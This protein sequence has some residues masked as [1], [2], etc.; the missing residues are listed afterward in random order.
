MTDVLLIQPPIS[1]FYLTAKRTFPYGLACIATALEAD[2]FSVSLFDALATGRSRRLPLP[3]EM[4]YLTPFY[5]QPDLS[6]FALFHHHR[7]FGYSFQYL[8]AVARAS[9]AFL[10]GISSLFTPYSDYALQTA[11]VV[12][13]AL[14]GCRVVLGGY[15]PTALPGSVMAHPAVDFLIRGQGETAM[16]ALARALKA[17]SGLEQVPGIVFRKPDA[18]LHIASPAVQ[19]AD[20]GGFFPAL[21]KVNLRYYR[22]AGRCGVVVAASRGCPMSCSYCCMGADSQMP[23]RR[24]S[25]ASVTAEI[26][27]AVSQYGAGL[28]D[29]EDENLSLDRRW[30][31]ALLDEMTRRYRGMN[32]ELRAMNGLF[33]PSLDEPMVAAMKNAG[34]RTL[35]LSLGSTDPAQ[36]KRFRRPDV[37]RS[38]DAALGWARTH[39]L[40]AVG[41]II[42]GAPD[43]HAEASLQDLLYLAR[44]RVLAGISVYYPAPDSLDFGRCEKL[45]MLPETFSLMRSS[46]LPLSHATTRREVV[47]LLRLGRIVNFMKRLA[48]SGRGLPMPG[49]VARCLDPRENRMETGVHL[50]AAFLNDGNIR[51]IT[52][53]GRVY[54]HEISGKLTRLFLQAL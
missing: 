4:A 1:D 31:M 9:G 46:A 14:P 49:A 36:L 26:D 7:H 22:R 13:Q 52:P 45:G 41:Y 39:G 11:E 17:K 28:I 35:N 2:G 6:P 23:Y 16:P 40:D 38:F 10:V 27:T 12:K 24:R 43:Q 15:H 34:F 44:R 37:S 20:D 25:V 30:F 51:G 18:T 48:D 21:E 19:A 5:G 3:P 47:T 50:L 33:P 54:P 8:S 29:F 32:L 42:V 53:E